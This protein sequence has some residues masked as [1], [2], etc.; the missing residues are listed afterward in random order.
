M[1]VWFLGWED[2]LEEELATHSS[3][4]AWEI[5]WTEE[6]SRL[7]SMGLQSQKRG[8][9]HAPHTQSS[10]RGEEA[11]VFILQ[12]QVSLTCGDNL[13]VVNFWTFHAY[14]SPWLCS[15][16]KTGKVPRDRDAD[17]GEGYKQNINSIQS[18]AMLSKC[19][20]WLWTIQG[21]ILSSHLKQLS[22]PANEN[23]CPPSGSPQESELG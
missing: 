4:P 9:M 18:S 21:S 11:G 2:P 17:T 14:L 15:W 13:E 16:S 3:I 22:Y 12:T 5:Q 8:A 7:W 19:L 6:P 20:S 23:K 10:S 1:W